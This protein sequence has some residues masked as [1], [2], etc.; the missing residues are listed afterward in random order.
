[1]TQEYVYDYSAGVG[2]YIQRARGY[3]WT[4]VNGEVF[5]ERGEHTG[6]LVA[7]TL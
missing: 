5:M 7:C 3:D 2:R 6:A 4:V 1:M